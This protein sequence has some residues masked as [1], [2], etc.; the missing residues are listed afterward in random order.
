[1]VSSMS[2]KA[3]TH[4]AHTT[5]MPGSTRSFYRERGFLC[6]VGRRNRSLT[7]M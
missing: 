5:S 3:V 2:A 7:M 6:E 4:R 1:M